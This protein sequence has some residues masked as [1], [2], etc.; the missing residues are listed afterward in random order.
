VSDPDAGDVV[1]TALLGTRNSVAGQAPAVSFNGT[2]FQLVYLLWPPSLLN[3]DAGVTTILLDFDLRDARGS[4]LPPGQ[5]I[6]P[7][8]ITVAIQSEDTPPG[9][10]APVPVCQ[11]QCCPE[12]SAYFALLL[13]SLCLLPLAHDH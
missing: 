11:S 5:N 1:T 7:V 13:H 12:S 4:F 10:Q 6:V 9:P 2:T 8:T 3:Y